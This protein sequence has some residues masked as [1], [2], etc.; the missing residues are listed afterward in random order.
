ML[1][2]AGRLAGIALGIAAVTIVALAALALFELDREVQLNR[3]VIAGLQVKDSL[4]ALRQEIG[5]LGYAA[6]LAA[7][8]VSGSHQAVERRAVEI[9][10]ELEYLE[11]NPQREDRP[12]FDDLTRAAQMLVVVAR[13]AASASNPR[14]AEELEAATQQAMSAVQ[15]M[16]ESQG[17]GINNR[18]VAQI[19]AGETLHAYV[20]WFLVG[21]ALVLIG[22]LG[23]YV[24][25]KAR[26]RLA[27]ERIE[28]LA[29]YDVLTGLPNRSLLADRLDREVERARRTSRG[30]ALLMFDLD[31]F[32]AVNDTWGHAAGDELLA[33]VGMRAME[34]VRAADTVGRLGG[35]EFLAILPEATHE[36]ALLVAEKLREA[37]SRPYALRAATASIGVS[38]GI[39]YF[40]EHGDNAAAL[41]RAADTALYE[42]KRRGKNR[43]LE[44]A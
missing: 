7:L 25:A 26:E 31:G 34:C 39:S 3:E 44:A 37:I 6:R 15:R 14:A 4:E 28:R 17:A 19:R 42:A 5:E 41:Q 16:L 20:S 29:H 23:F 11:Q 21:S 9:G 33:M 10:A 38:V 30:F 22:L 40:G 24:R 43:V 27:A 2:S 32:K 18:M 1:P 8:G 35:D 12:A 13:S 36:G